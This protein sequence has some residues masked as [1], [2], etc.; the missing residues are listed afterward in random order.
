MTYFETKKYIKE[1]LLQICKEYAD[2]ES[3]KI[4]IS[5]FKKDR[6]EL[7]LC[8][9]EEAPDRSSEIED[10]IKR[11]K[12][13]E[14]LSYILGKT[15]F[16]G[17]SLNVSNACLTPRADTEVVCE[18]AI[19]FLK[20]KKCQD[21]LDICT[22]SGCI[23]LAVAANTDSLVDALDISEK[24]I[25]IAEKN[26]KGTFLQDK[27]S[28]SICDVL[29]ED[30]LKITKKYDLIISN[31]PYIPTKDIENLSE[32]VKKEPIS[33]LDGGEDGLVFYKRFL[34]TL[35]NMLKKGGKIIFE[36]GYDQK[37]DMENLI[38][39]YGYKHEFFN[40]YSKN[41]RGVMIDV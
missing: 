6:K 2:Y 16:F 13:G 30:F 37:E 7:S 1:S 22:G 14:P 21:V 19:E 20:N 26:A 8:Y 38:S 15:D 41:I 9:R 35:P 12:S 33:A 23:A 34:K 18:K 24:A 11:R 32:E 40:D 31:P 5:V 10:I 39:K 28:F 3:E 4:M 29:S 17:L 36:I 27:V 25:E